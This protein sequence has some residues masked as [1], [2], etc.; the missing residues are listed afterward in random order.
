LLTTWVTEFASN[1]ATAT[2]MMPVLAATAQAMQMDPLLLMIPATFAASVCNF[3]LPSATG[4]NAIVFA[5]GHV[6]VPQM[7]RAGIVLDLLCAV[8]LTALLYVL[9]IVVFDISLSSLP[10]WAK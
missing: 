8:L 1:T 3:M 5:S 9:G 7:V 2:L 6:T 10:S 4:P